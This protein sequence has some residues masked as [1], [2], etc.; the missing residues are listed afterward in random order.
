MNVLLVLGGFDA[1]K[2]W[3]LIHVQQCLDHEV[4]APVDEAL[5]ELFEF[6]KAAGRLIQHLNVL[7]SGQLTLFLDALLFHVASHL[8]SV[9]VRVILANL[10]DEGLCLILR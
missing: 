9:N 10:A 5:P 8:V 2:R 4:L 1:E 7:S 3:L 6:H